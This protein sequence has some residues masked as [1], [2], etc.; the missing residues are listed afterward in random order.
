M[1]WHELGDPQPLRTYSSHAI[2][3]ARNGCSQAGTRIGGS[4]P[5][6]VT[7]PLASVS[8]QGLALA[9]GRYGTVSGVTRSSISGAVKAGGWTHSI[10]H[11]PVP[12]HPP[13]KRIRPLW[14]WTRIT[15]LISLAFS[16]ARVPS[17]RLR[18]E[19]GVSRSIRM[20]RPS[21]GGSNL[22]QGLASFTLGSRQGRISSSNLTSRPAGY[23]NSMARTLRRYF[24]NYSPTCTS[25]A[26]ALTK[27]SPTTIEEVA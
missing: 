12:Y 22:L 27:C 8:Q 26:P 5:V 13:G 23:G 25:S 21:F 17:Q 4:V 1:E 3:A 19:L 2:G 15:L 6:T 16:M 14:I 24:A 10:V 7:T 11:P 20:M 18:P 9:F